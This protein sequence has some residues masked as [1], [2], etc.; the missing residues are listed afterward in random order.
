MKP[1]YHIMLSSAETIGSLNTGFETVNLQ[2]PTGLNELGPPPKGSGVVRRP[3]RCGDTA[4]AGPRVEAP[5]KLPAPALK[6]SIM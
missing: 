2:R 6:L 5:R 4:A 1:L 3:V